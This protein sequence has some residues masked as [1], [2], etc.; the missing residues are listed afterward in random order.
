MKLT[1]SLPHTGSKV[2]SSSK[3]KRGW[4]WGGDDGSSMVEFAL[5]LPPLMLLMTGIFA[6]GIATANYGTLTNATSI[7]AMQLAISRGQ[8]SDPCAV[9]SAAV[10]AAA[11]YLEQ[12][13]LSFTFVLNGTTYT[14][15]T[16][17][18]GAANLVQGQGAQV[19]VTY[20]CSLVAYKFS[21]F[22]S[23]TLTAKTSELVQ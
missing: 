4:P 23:C 19:T 9:G 2:R 5:C 6:F 13:N 14:G 18:A 11:P 3:R 16:C 10:Y 20:P 22:S 21:T 17:T 8:I 1:V 15:T 12:A 7:A